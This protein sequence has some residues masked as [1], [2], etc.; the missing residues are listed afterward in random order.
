[1]SHPVRCLQLVHKLW[2]CDQASALKILAT[3]CI[4]A[5]TCPRL[6]N[7]RLMFDHN[8]KQKSNKTI[9]LSCPAEA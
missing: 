4:P 1:M 5:A 3:L 9:K 2:T 8:L 6:S 7:T